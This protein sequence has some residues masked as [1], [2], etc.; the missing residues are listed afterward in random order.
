MSITTETR[1]EAHE[2]IKPKRFTKYMQILEILGNKQLTAREIEKEMCKNKYSKYFDLDH[3]RP[4]L[5]ELRDDYNEV[6]EAGA[7]EDKL[8]HRTVAIFRRTTEVEKMEIE[9][10]NHYPCID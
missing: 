5:T 7:K 10:E 3:V 4:R 8:T 1:R 2:N 9:N 6:T